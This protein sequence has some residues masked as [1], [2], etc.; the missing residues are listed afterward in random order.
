[1]CAYNRVNDVYS[2]SD[3]QLLNGI[4]RESFDF[5]GFVTS[6]WGAVH[7]ISDLMSG[8]DIEQ[9]GNPSGTPREISSTPDRAHSRGI[10]KST[11]STLV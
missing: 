4:L 3:D 11:R 9:P 6:D 7:R 1:M 2:C 8:T 10:R 5:A